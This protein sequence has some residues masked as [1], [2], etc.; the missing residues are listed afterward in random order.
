MYSTTGLLQYE[1]SPTVTLSSEAAPGTNVTLQFSISSYTYAP[2]IHTTNW[3]YNGM[4]IDCNSSSTSD[5]YLFSS[6]S[7]TILNA[8]ENDLG[9]Y[10]V[11]VTK[12]V[13]YPYSNT[14]TCPLILN[15][16]NHTAVYSPVV[17]CLTSEG[18]HTN[19]LLLLFSFL[20]SV[21]SDYFSGNNISCQNNEI[22]KITTLYGITNKTLSFTKEYTSL[23]SSSPDLY[24]SDGIQA[25]YLDD[26]GQPF[27][28][29]NGSH[30]VINIP[31][32]NES[33]AGE[34]TIVF[35][36]QCYVIYYL[37]CG[38]Y[39]EELLCYDLNLH[40]ILD[41]VLQIKINTLG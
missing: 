19:R 15:I 6:T 37:G 30:I 26:S 34:Y 3:F 14:H 28:G 23:Y 32:Y 25:S 35:Y 11:R 31:Q 7:L 20:V 18:M 9:Q 12:I 38:Y 4:C 17:F 24:Y 10:E 36:T 33:W 41:Q 29:T 2:S 40:T 39:F 8:S 1:S 5:R 27:H 13:P 22:N 16:L 21:I